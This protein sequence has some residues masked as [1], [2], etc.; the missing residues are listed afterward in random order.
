MRTLPPKTEGPSAHGWPPAGATSARCAPSAA[1]ATQSEVFRP[2]GEHRR[3]AS[4]LCRCRSAAAAAA[5]SPSVPLCRFTVV[6]STGIMAQLIATFPYD[7]PAKN[8]VGW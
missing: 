5:H 2:H 3:C 4:R 1:A 6:M 7:A 8:E